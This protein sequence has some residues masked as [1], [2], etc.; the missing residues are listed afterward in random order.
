M[1][2]L[3][4]SASFQCLC[5]GSTAII[6]VVIPSARGPSLN[7]YRRQIL[8]YKD[9]PRAETVNESLRHPA[10]T[11]VPRLLAKIKIGESS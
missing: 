8:T 9:S 6:N 11:V 2:Q 4:I 3:A 1:S 10:L 5:C 7:F